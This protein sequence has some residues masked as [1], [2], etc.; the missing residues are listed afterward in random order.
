M[1]LPAEQQVLAL[2]PVPSDVQIQPVRGAV[3]REAFIRF[4]YALYRHDPLW[5]PPLDRSA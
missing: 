1:A 4:P 3:D 5:V 2:P